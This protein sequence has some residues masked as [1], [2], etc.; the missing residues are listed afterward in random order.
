M[1]AYVRACVR[2]YVRAIV[3]SSFRL[4]K[5]E[6]YD[7]DCRNKIVIPLSYSNTVIPF[8]NLI[9]ALVNNAVFIIS[10]FSSRTW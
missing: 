5:C 10:N 9:Y 8:V 2:A 7:H 6:S 3:D 1:R 4:R